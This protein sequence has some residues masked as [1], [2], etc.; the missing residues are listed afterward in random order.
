[1]GFSPT[2]QF[3]LK[4]EIH[5]NL[6]HRPEGRRNSIYV[7]QV[8]TLAAGVLRGLLIFTWSTLYHM[9]NAPLRSDVPRTTYN[10]LQNEI[11]VLNL[12]LLKEF[13]IRHEQ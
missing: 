9:I 11:K 10:F 7:P 12:P 13:H 1:M 3:W 4:P 2:I 8:M 6:I 5:F